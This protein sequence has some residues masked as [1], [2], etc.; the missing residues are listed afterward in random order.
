MGEEG[1]GGGG[2]VS[3]SQVDPSS[4]LSV[5][6]SWQSTCT[7]V[8]NLIIDGERQARIKC[9]VQEHH[10]LCSTPSGYLLHMSQ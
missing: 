8:D 1:G 9:S 6:L 7:G 5:I 2:N 4:L 3:E 10:G